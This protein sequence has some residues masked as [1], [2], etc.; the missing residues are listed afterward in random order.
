[1]TNTSNAPTLGLIHGALAGLSPLRANTLALV[2]GVSTVFGFAP[3]HAWPVYLLSISLLLW[4]VDGAKRQKKWRFAA[5]NRGWFWGFGFTLFG[6]HWLVEPFL[7]D[8]KQHGAFIWMPLILMPSGMGL[9]FGVATLVASLFWSNGPG[10]IFVLV[11][12]LAITEWLRG[13]LFGGFPW[14]WPGTV[15]EP[16]SA[17]SQLASIFGLYGLSILTLLFAA[18]PAALADYRPSGSAFGRVVPSLLCVLIAGTGWGWGSQRLLTTPTDPVQ[19]VRIVDVGVPQA[20]KYDPANQVAIL[21]AFLVATGDDFPAEPRLI[22]WPEGALPVALL[23]TPDALD[24]VTERLGDRTLITGTVR[25][26]RL[27]TPPEFFNSLAVLT[28]ESRVRGARTIYDKHRLVPFGELP[29]S[30]IVPFGERISNLLPS[31]LQRLAKSGFTPGPGGEALDLPDGSKFLPLICY[32]ALFPE[33]SIGRAADADFLVNISIDGWFG[34]GVGPEQ[35]FAQTRY[36]AIETGRPLVRTASLG[37]SGV[38]DA[39]GRLT[40]QAEPV[41]DTNG[42]PITVIDAPIPAETRMTIASS[43][44]MLLSVLLILAC[45]AVNFTFAQRVD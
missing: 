22:V 11:A 36:R 6:M 15:W 27:Q 37:R 40:T 31:A 1:M 3:F 21:R 38:V 12:A 35:H 25:I 32:E 43:H 7:V 39:F 24:A 9:F 17:M 4:L 30:K 45:V 18:A 19:S 26:D 16:G 28:A 8:F 13:T 5:F 10:R 34:G 14:N 29:A 20:E 42:W 41:V 2:L 33:L 44:S 23:Q